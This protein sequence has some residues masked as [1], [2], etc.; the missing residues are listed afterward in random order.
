MMYISAVFFFL[1]FSISSV[2][3]IYSDEAFNIDFHYALLGQ[4][5]QHS[6]FF[7]QPNPVSKASLIYT[8]TDRSILGAINPKDGS[9]VWR[10]QLNNCEYYDCF[11]RAAEGQDTIVSA[12]EKE[13]SA[14]N[15]ADGKLTW[16]ASLEGHTIE[17]LQILDFPSINE[18]SAVKDALVLYNGSQLSV[19]RLS[20]DTGKT[21]WVYEYERY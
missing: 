2:A 3:A 20:G 16:R 10:Q 5:L 15:A 12:D 1:I 7:H 18:E 9:I 21:L 6:T 4:P 11:L 13:V 19:H 14:W 8:V 17:D